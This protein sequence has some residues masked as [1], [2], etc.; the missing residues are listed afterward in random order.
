MD[1][2]LS[3][4]NITVPSAQTVSV[5]SA[6]QRQLAFSLSFEAN[7]N[8]HRVA[9]QLKDQSGRNALQAQER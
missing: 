9:Q 2:L 5:Q 7:P 8:S 6:S 4:A 3:T 1:T